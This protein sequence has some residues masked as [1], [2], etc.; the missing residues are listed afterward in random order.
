MAHNPPSIKT[1]VSEEDFIAL[2]ERLGAA[3]VARELSVGIRNVYARRAAIEKRR[4]IKIASP[5][6]R[7]LLPTNW[8]EQEDQIIALDNVRDEVWI[9]GSDAHYFPHILPTA[10]RGL[11][12]VARALKPQCI[13]LNGD[14]IDLAKVSRHAARGWEKRLDVNDEVE[15]IKTRLGEIDE[16]A[17]GAKKRRTMGNHD[18]RYETRLANA[19]PEYKDIRGT[20][21]RDHIPEW[22]VATAYFINGHTYIVHRWHSGIHATHNNVVKGGVNFVTGDLHSLKVTPWTSMRGTHYGVDTGTLAD[23]D[24]P[25]FLYTEGKPKN[26][27]S[28]FVVLTFRDG[29][30]LPPEPAEVIGEGELWFR[31]KVW[32]V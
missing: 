9:V 5:T 24:G 10:H 21:L 14:I 22:E 29:L 16:A 7:H 30:L 26:W 19:A 27:R 8:V 18:R 6:A 31:G 13:C 32:E 23:T 20:R 3:G 15:C 12:A 28:G 2:F 25:Q 11:L 17:P 1:Q 4:R